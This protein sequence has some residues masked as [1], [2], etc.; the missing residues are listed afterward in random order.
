MEMVRRI[1]YEISIYIYELGIEGRLLDMQVK[2]L[3]DSLENERVNLVKDYLKD[4]SKDHLKIWNYI[5]GLSS[6]ELLSLSNMIFILG[7]D[8][9]ISALDKKVYPRGYRLMSKIPKLPL[10]VLENTISMFGSLQGILKASLLDLCKIEGIGEVRAKTIKE[11]LRKQQEKTLF[12]KTI[13]KQAKDL[14]L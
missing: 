10:G 1:E 14:R 11:G 12:E 5:G 4:N 3:V 13:I 9:E 6:E 2:E 8:D 7:Y